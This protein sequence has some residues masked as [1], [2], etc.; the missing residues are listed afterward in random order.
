[1]RCPKGVAPQLSASG[2]GRDALPLPVR[3]PTPLLAWEREMKNKGLLNEEGSPVNLERWT[4]PLRVE[5]Q[6]IARQVW[7]FLGVMGLN[8][9]YLGHLS[10][11]R[12]EAAG[13]CSYGSRVGDAPLASG[14]VEESDQLQPRRGL[15]APAAQ[16]SG[17]RAGAP[18]GRGHQTPGRPR[19][20]GA[21]PAGPAHEAR[22]LSLSL[23][24]SLLLE[25]D[26]P[27]TPPRAQM[28]VER[29]E[30]WWLIA[31]KLVELGLLKPMAPYK[32]FQ[33][34][35]QRVADGPFAVSKT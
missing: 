13:A 27:P 35:G 32:F 28:N 10:K 23:F 20:R 22:A 11:D 30:D 5:A 25:A 29:I 4:K 9:L 34:H 19:M 14:P 31:A 15:L 6:E 21:G 33:A 16:L 8:Y 3:G 7:T 12:W 17:A 18:E 24:L 26:W 1:M 2:V